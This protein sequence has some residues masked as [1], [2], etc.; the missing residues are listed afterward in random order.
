MAEGE[1]LVESVADAEDVVGF[2]SGESFKIL[3]GREFSINE[4]LGDP[5]PGGSFGDIGVVSFFGS[6]EWGENQEVGVLFFEFADL[7]S[8]GVGGLRNDGFAGF[9]A[10]LD[11]E[12]CVEETEEMV[13][14]CDGACGGFTTAP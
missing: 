14:F 1:C 10:V 9:R 5:F 8:N 7:L 4:K 6:D 13:D 2:E 3:G 12:F 11:A